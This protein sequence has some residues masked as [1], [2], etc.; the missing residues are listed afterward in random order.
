MNQNKQYNP[1]ALPPDFQLAQAHAK[2]KQVGYQNQN[3]QEYCPCCNMAINKIPIGVCEDIIRLQ[4]L[5]EGIPLFFQSIKLY[6]ILLL[7][8][9]VL[10]GIYNII[11]TSDL[12]YKEYHFNLMDNEENQEQGCYHFIGVAYTVNKTELQL[13]IQAVLALLGTFLVTAGLFLIK[14]FQQRNLHF[15]INSSPSDFTIL[16]RNYPYTHEKQQIEQYFMKYFNV[17]SSSIV[18]IIRPLN[19]QDY[20]NDQ[21]K[22]NEKLQEQQKI[23][24]LMTRPQE[25]REKNDILNQLMHEIQVLDKQISLFEQQVT[26]NNLYQRTDYVLVTL[27]EESLVDQ[28]LDICNQNHWYEIIMDYVG[29]CDKLLYYL[30]NDKQ[31][32][33]FI[34]GQRIYIRR[35]PEPLDIIWQNFNTSHSEKRC[36]RML[37]LSLNFLVVLIGAFIVYG[38]SYTQ[39]QAQSSNTF[40]VKYVLSGLCALAIL[41]I[42]QILEMLIKITSKYEKHTTYTNETRSVM[43]T[44]TIMQF[45]NTALVPFGL[46]IFTDFDQN[47]LAVSLFFIFL[48]N[49]IILPILEILDPL[50][51]IKL[52]KQNQILKEQDKRQIILT[53]QQTHELF[54]GPD[55]RIADKYSTIYKSIL[56]SMFYLCI[57]PYGM[58]MQILSLFLYYWACKYTLL[59]RCSYP[60]T[61]NR[62]L[63]DSTLQLLGI[64][65]ILISAGSA[66]YQFVLIKTYSNLII[67][68]INM[69]I[70]CLCVGIYLYFRFESKAT[71]TESALSLNYFEEKKKFSTDYEKC[72]P[73][74]MKQAQFQQQYKLE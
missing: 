12:C 59:R 60:P 27:Q 30:N 34:N 46:F 24:A 73:I 21:K 61:I 67:H 13:T 20:L 37:A 32:W 63:N 69:I 31:Q 8:I 44:Q 71:H 38:I 6:S 15:S 50:Y 65:P 39:N 54:E 10:V 9:F 53:Q 35:A 5:G 51:I 56:M 28:I 33:K 7:L 70:S 41:I 74:T 57:F 26:L 1:F 36:K 64:S 16:L 19:I 29:C 18:K 47:N 40:Y 3:Q 17:N 55:Y 14:W 2:A 22:K 42:N 25:V 58:M 4:F 48:G 11:T 66:C 45:I 23:Y 43:V 68:I 62:N 72:N 52:I 49:L